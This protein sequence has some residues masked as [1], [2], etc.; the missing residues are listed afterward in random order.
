VHQ[1]WDEEF[2]TKAL[3]E[4]YNSN[5]TVMADSILNNITVSKLTLST[6]IPSL[7]HSYL[8]IGTTRKQGPCQ[9][10]LSYTTLP[11]QHKSVRNVLV[12]MPFTTKQ[13]NIDLNLI[14]Y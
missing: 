9:Q 6:M 12:K 1:V 2:V 10:V 3:K 11:N 5:P 4:N 8:T 14:F 13:K 7:D